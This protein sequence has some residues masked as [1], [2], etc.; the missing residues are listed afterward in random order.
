MYRVPS[1]KSSTLSFF[2]TNFVACR[3]IIFSRFFLLLI[4]LSYFRPFPVLTV[5][6]M[7]PYPSCFARFFFCSLFP[8]TQP[9]SINHAQPTPPLISF[10]IST[11]S[12]SLSLFLVH[13][14]SLSSEY[15]SYVITGGR[16]PMSISPGMRDERFPIISTI[17]INRSYRLSVA[18]C[19][20]IRL[21]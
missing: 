16:H 2:R 1:T 3:S 14:L 20:S 8:L 10:S 6:K 19:S 21:Q 17:L 5:A 18:Q 15:N 12:L 9:L 4:S 11:F 7:H 13:T